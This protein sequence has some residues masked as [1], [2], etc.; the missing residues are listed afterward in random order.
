[1]YIQKAATSE[2]SW[3]DVLVS[4]TSSHKGF[5]KGLLSDSG[6][7]GLCSPFIAKGHMATSFCQLIWNYLM[8]GKGVSDVSTFEETVYII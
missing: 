3:S 1:M 2:T 7:R 6:Q 4:G 8:W 5:G